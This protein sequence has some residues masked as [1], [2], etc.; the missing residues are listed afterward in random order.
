MFKIEREKDIR[1]KII[2]MDFQ[3]INFCELIKNVIHP[4]EECIL[5]GEVDWTYLVKLS[6]DHNLLP[7]FME[8]ASRYFSYI[9]RLEYDRETKECL[10]VVAGQVRRTS[11]FLRVYEAFNDAGL[12][13][14]VM[15]GLICRELYGRLADHRPSGDEDILIR[16]CE[17][18]KAKNVLIANGYV[19]EF[20]VQTEAQ[21]EQVQEISFIHPKEK[22]HIE[23][24]LNPMG[25]E[26]AALSHMSDCFSNVFE[27]Y[28]EVE[29]SGVKVRTMSHQD[30]LLFLILHAFKH[31]IGGGFGIRQML[32]LLLYQEHYGKEIDLEE[33]SRILRSFQTDVF[34]SDLIHIGN[35]YFG[36]CLPNSYAQNC[37]DDLLIDMISCGV[38]G[39][40]TQVQETAGK[41]MILATG[42]YIKNKRSNSVV[43]V[44]KSIFPS[45]AYMLKYSPYLEEKPWLV[46]VA[47]VRRWGRFIRKSWQHDGNL[48]LESMRISQRRM[49][50]LKKYDLV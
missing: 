11:A 35:S 10:A 30:H 50:L 41:T 40:K 24:H 12:H 19:A 9:S 31:F 47:W 38:F 4:N 1:G 17:Y 49:K 2:I 7:V 39:N 28:R 8:G 32:D 14:I 16:P 42:N 34:W 26:N 23:L 13:P 44:L 36:F 48:A 6:K 25:R 45:K 18:E 46:P 43:M 33:L 27:K 20:E 21:L 3:T 22:L 15:K 29:I 5:Q 37:P